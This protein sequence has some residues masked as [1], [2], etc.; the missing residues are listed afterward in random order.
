VLHEAVTT[1]RV[2]LLE[3]LLAL[4]SSS[5]DDA[6]LRQWEDL[7]DQSDE[8]GCTPLM[9]ACKSGSVDMARLLRRLQVSAGGPERAA[10]LANAVAL[11]RASNYAEA[12]LTLFPAEALGDDAAETSPPHDPHRE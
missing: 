1:D 10:N 8:S 4:S 7:T 9:L 12:L 5:A 2:A 3:H 11:S 6:V